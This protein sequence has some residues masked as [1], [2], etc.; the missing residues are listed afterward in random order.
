[1]MEPVV[2]LNSRNAA[3]KTPEMLSV[4]LGPMFSPQAC[5]DLQNADRSNDPPTR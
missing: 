1:M 4:R 2:Q 5:V 3:Q